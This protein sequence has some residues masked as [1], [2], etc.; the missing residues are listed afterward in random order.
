MQRQIQAE[1]SLKEASS[2]ASK[3]K[4]KRKSR[5]GDQA[6]EGE[7]KEKKRRK[8][9]YDENG[10]RIRSKSAAPA[11][12]DG[13]DVASKDVD[14][15]RVSTVAQTPLVSSMSAI[16]DAMFST[17]S[18]VRGMFD[19]PSFLEVNTP[20]PKK[21]MSPQLTAEEPKSSNEEATKK[22]KSSKSSKVTSTYKFPAG[23]KPTVNA[24]GEKRY[25]CPVT[26]CNVNY[27]RRDTL[28]Q[29][30]NVCLSCMK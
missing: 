30:M 28:G 6:I 20:M 15:G 18:R 7:P 22:P 2:P 11:N 4:K 25:T 19:E 29:H 13:V 12:D 23:W 27:S 17:L 5:S 8:K 21:M 24:E 10:N 16:N 1:H 9:Q 14:S 3:Q 26:S